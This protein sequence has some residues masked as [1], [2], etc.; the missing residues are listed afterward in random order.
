MADLS[1]FVSFCLLLALLLFHSRLYLLFLMAEW[2]QGRKRESERESVSETDWRKEG[3]GGWGW[4]GEERGGRAP[5]SRQGFNEEPLKFAVIERHPCP[6]QKGPAPLR[7]HAVVSSP[8]PFSI[9]PSWFPSFLSLSVLCKIFTSSL[10]CNR[11]LLPPP[12]S[13]TLFTSCPPLWSGHGSCLYLTNRG[14]PIP[15]APGLWSS[16]LQ[17]GGGV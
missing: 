6:L 10:S 15:S 1:P 2:R 13:P 7:R 11:L 17:D 3:W 16:W 9:S 12:L 14:G 8:F 5:V 4:R